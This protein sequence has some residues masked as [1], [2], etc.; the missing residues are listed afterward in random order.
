VLHAAL[1]A[2]FERRVAR[3]DPLLAALDGEARV[4]ALAERCALPAARVRQALVPTELQ[5][6]DVFLQSVST[7]AL[8]R[9]RL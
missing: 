1:R 3:R 2:R 4:L 5:R 6:P 7:L 9:L 8:M